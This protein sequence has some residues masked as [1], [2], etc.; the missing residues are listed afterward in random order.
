MII[1]ESTDNQTCHPWMNTIICNKNILSKFTVKF[2][3]TIRKYLTYNH[4]SKSKDL[5]LDIWDP[6]FLWIPEH[7][8]HIS[9][10]IFRLAQSGS[11]S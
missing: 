10:P 9:A 5:T 8:I 7:S 1:S 4:S 2:K 11:K 3:V 6:R